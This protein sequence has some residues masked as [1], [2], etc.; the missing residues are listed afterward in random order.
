M[1]KLVENMF[2]SAESMDGLMKR[3]DLK[4]TNA[5]EQTVEIFRSTVKT[6]LLQQDG[7]NI[8]KK[9]LVKF[10]DSLKVEVTAKGK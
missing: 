4:V 2:D 8:N 5:V 7:D 6:W 9:E 1:N 10:I 3:M